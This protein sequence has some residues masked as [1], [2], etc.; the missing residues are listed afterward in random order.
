MDNFDKIEN[1][2]NDVIKRV[3]KNKS[4]RF[5][6]DVAVMTVIGTVLGSSIGFFGTIYSSNFKFNRKLAHI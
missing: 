6:H 1:L 4:K 2:G 3:D 5:Y